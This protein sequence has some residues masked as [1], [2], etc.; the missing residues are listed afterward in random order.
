MSEE[1]GATPGALHFF[2]FFGE[3]ED[4]VVP[5]G[6]KTFSRLEFKPLGSLPLLRAGGLGDFELGEAGGVEFDEGL[7]LTIVG[8]GRDASGGVVGDFGV[9]FL[10]EYWFLSRLGIRLQAG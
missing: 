7:V 6:V 9:I 3:L 5:L 10:N 4:L 2:V 8:G 1:G